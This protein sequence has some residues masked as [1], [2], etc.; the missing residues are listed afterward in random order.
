MTC[1]HNSQSAV[2]ALG[3]R[4]IEPGQGHEAGRAL[5]AQLYEAHVGGEMP[6]IVIGERGKPYFADKSVHFSISHTPRHVFCALS[7]RPIGI[8]AE[9]LTRNIDLRLAGKILSPTE[10]AQFEAATD[11]RRALLTFWVLKEADGKQNGF[12]INA[13]PNKTAFSLDDPRVTE[14][15]GC[16]V[17]IVD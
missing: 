10:K 5:L 2:I 1:K 12:G 9:E 11:K 15:D 7:S 16:L 6:A 17:A 4:E 8:D 14:Q 13:N 3:C